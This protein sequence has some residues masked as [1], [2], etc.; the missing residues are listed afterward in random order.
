MLRGLPW[1]LAV[2]LLLPTSGWGQGPGL[3]I[4]A[5][6]TGRPDCTA[7]TN[8]VNDQ[9]WCFFA[10][11]PSHVYYRHAGAW[12]ALLT[13]GGDLTATYILQTPAGDLPNAQALSAL[14][15]GLLLNTTGTGVLSQYAGASCP[16]QAISALTASGVPT[17]MATGGVTPGSSLAGVVVIS[18]TATTG[19]VVFGVAQ[20]DTNY[21]VTGWT[22][23]LAGTPP[24]VS[25]EY[26]NKTTAGFDVRISSP[27]GAGN[28]VEVNWD[29][30]RPGV[31]GVLSGA[32]VA[33]QVTYWT[34]VATLGG[35][36]TLLFGQT[37]A[38][39][40]NP[41][42]S[43]TSTL[44]AQ[45]TTTATDI[46]QFT[47][48]FGL[49]SNQGAAHTGANKDKV[50]LYA[51]LDALAGTGDTW[52]INSVL[53][54]AIGSGSYNAQGYELDF[55][56]LN[57]HRG[58]TDAEAGLASP[59]SYGLSI[60]GASLFRS[61]AA[62]LIAGSAGTW[63]RGIVIANS[64]ISAT[65]SSF[66]DLTS[67]DKSIDIR[68]TPNY[69]IYQDQPVSKNLL[70]GGAILG[71]STIANLPTGVL[72]RVV[73]TT[74]DNALKCYNG[75]SWA[76][77]NTI[78]A[79]TVYR[80][81]TIV[82][83]ADNGA[84]LLDGDIGPQGRQ[85]FAPVAGTVVQVTVAADGGTPSVVPRLMHGAS[86]TNLLSGALSTAGSG[87]IACAKTT[88]IAGFDGVTTCSGTLTGTALA[89][90]DFLEILSGTAGGVAKRLTLVITWS[91][92]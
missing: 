37:V 42:I 56:N 43:T 71:P 13:G 86:P 48:V 32:G 25:S 11:D 69:G 72:G 62:L 29:L 78:N 51:G 70:A 91:E 82:V 8:P 21:V 33:G 73:Y 44:A 18:G 79:A 52:A 61:T 20:S 3:F 14:G 39:I 55:N 4:A 77:C 9:T 59:V 84:A 57:A 88:G 17:C 90:G 58:D 23:P 54:Q 60:S 68:G 50:A 89:A 2:L 6:G 83:G 31:G 75:S 76:A 47:G 63:N 46:R 74:D 64:S 16:G 34:G 67:P 92:P 35:S 87:G 80:Q 81:C 12:V 49:T 85:C 28:S 7:I 15:T 38:P 40:G 22:R 1:L 65:G 5:P 19:S 26:F 24:S 53:T 45:A 30:N 41:T 27:P 66:Q 10:S 36:P